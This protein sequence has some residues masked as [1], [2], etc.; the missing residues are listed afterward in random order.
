ISIALEGALEHKDSM[1]NT[2]VIRKGNV[3]VMSAGTGIRHSEYNKSA[4]EQVKFLQIWVLPNRRNVEPRYDQ[5][6]LNRSERHNRLQQV[7]SPFAD[8]A[9]VWIHQDAW[10]HLGHFE[11][12]KMAEYVLKRPGNGVYAFLISGK[13]TLNGQ[14]L[15]ERDGYGV[16]DV[17]RISLQADAE[18]EVLL[19]ELPMR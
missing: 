11:A 12:G 3:Q 17:E 13:M 8:D 4:E 10:F 2:A 14:P 16:W 7:L 6:S 9:G 15:E 19:M 1:G 18:A 5:I